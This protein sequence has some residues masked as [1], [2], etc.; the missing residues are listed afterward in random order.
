M[1]ALKISILLALNPSGFAATHYVDLNSSNPTPPYTTWATAAREIQDAVDA[2]AAGDEVVTTNGIYR[3]VSVDKP[4]NLRS[5]NGSQFTIIDARGSSRCAFLADGTSLSGFTLT[6]GMEYVYFGG[7]GGGGVFG[8]TLENCTL[9]GNSAMS[10]DPFQSPGGGGAFGSILRNCTI[11]GN[12]SFGV[13]GGQ[14]VGGGVCNCTLEDCTLAGNRAIGDGLGGGAAYSTLSNCAVLTNQ[15]FSVSGGSEGGAFFGDGGGAYQCMMTNCTLAGN[16]ADGD[17]GGAALSTLDSCTLTGNNAGWGGGGGAYSSLLDHCTLTNNWAGSGGGAS[18]CT[19]SDCLLTDNWAGFW[20]GA[21]VASTLTDC[22]LTGN[23]GADA[24]GGAYLCALNNCQLISN[25]VA[26][27]FPGLGGGASWS[28]LT[29]CWLVGNVVTGYGG[30]AWN[31]SLN[32]CALSGNSANGITTYLGYQSGRGG[33]VS[34][35]VSINCTLV[36]NSAGVG[37]GAARGAAM[38][39]CILYFNE[40]DT[41]ANYDT[42]SAL[43]YCCTTPMPTNGFGTI[44]DAPLFV[45]ETGGNFRLQANSPCINAGNNDYVTAVTDLDGNPRILGGTVDIGAYEFATPEL[46]LQHLSDLVNQSSLAAK[47]PLLASLDAAMSSLQRG[48]IVSAINQLQAFQNKVRAQVEPVDAALDGELSQLAL[49][50]A[51]ALDAE[52]GAKE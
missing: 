6:N 3:P 43:A 36:G 23:V 32:N 34:G 47:Q 2:A 5:V 7:G 19:M 40:A 4:L 41:N 44:T 20:G 8:G 1:K 28:T 35:G 38:T 17:G 21:A 31:S 33:G 10:N 45:D 37:G 50:V 46:L 42:S 22:A 16:N 52:K 14:S 39:N 26:N 48:N 30:G 24:G 29:N 25:S 27:S 51:A 18:D 13:D 9:V 49:E 12:Y 15:A 11:I